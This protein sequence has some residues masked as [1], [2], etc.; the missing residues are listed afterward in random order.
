MTTTTLA[1]ANTMAAGTAET[2]GSIA[3]AGGLI[4]VA[5]AGIV[6]FIAAVV[7]VLRSRGYETGGKAM[8]LLLIL[9]FPVLA[10][11]VWFIWG[12]NSTI[13]SPPRPTA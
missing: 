7:S 12:R 4:A 1:S 13:M 5:F 6:L 11:I 8:W 9:V 3:L 10:P 2:A